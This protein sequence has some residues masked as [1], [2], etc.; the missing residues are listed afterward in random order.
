MYLDNLLEILSF[1][2]VYKD[3][4]KAANCRKCTEFNIV[5]KFFFFKKKEKEKTASAYI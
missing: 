1:I 3:N 5:L 2:Y 4:V